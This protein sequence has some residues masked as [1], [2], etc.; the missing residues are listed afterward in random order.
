MKVY[1]DSKGNRLRFTDHRGILRNVRAGGLSKRVLE[2]VGIRLQRVIE[3]RAA[4]VPLEPESVRWVAE[5]GPDLRGKLERLE[6]IEPLAKRE[7]VTLGDFLSH[8]IASRSDVK[9]QTKTNL[10]AAARELLTYF[11]PET[12]IASINSGSAELWFRWMR[13]ER[14][15]ADNTARRNAGRAAQFFKHA[16]RRK[17]LSENPFDGLPCRVHASKPERERFI[18]RDEARAMMDASNSSEWRA[19]IALSRFGGA[20]IPSEAVPLKWSDID[21]QRLTIRLTSPKTAHHELQGQRT[22][23]LFPE[24][25]DAL[26][27]LWDTK[28]DGSTDWIFPNLRNTGKNL[29]TH[30]L[31]IAARAGVE[32]LPKPFHNMRSSRA[33]ELA[34]EYPAHVCSSWLGHSVAIAQAHYLRVQPTDFAR[35]VERTQTLTGTEDARYLSRAREGELVARRVAQNTAKQGGIDGKSAVSR[36]AK[37]TEIPVNSSLSQAVQNNVAPRLGVEPRT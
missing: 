17:L 16:V 27:E 13:G 36:S 9:P 28:P 24:L 33:I 14:G 26:N 1:S 25:A 7:T 5:L 12:E 18:T 10:N 3:C 2:A 8:Y 35:A 34:K 15:L 6:L 23:P 37:T 31:R 29:R 32:R 11:R 20:R 21:W 19:L 30:L 4:G 22:I